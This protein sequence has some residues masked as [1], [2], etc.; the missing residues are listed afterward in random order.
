MQDN[1][2]A[3]STIYI[4]NISEDVWPFISAMSDNQAKAYEID[5]NALL[6]DRH[7]FSNLGEENILLILPTQIEPDFMDYFM[8]LFTGKNIR[9]IV[10]KIHTGEICNDILKDPN[11]MAEID[12]AANSS[13]RLEIVSYSASLQFLHLIRTLKQKHT[14]II[15]PESP[16]EEDAWTINFFGSKSGIRQLAQQSGTF[17]PDFK[18]PDGLICMGI[19]DA[20]KIAAN[21]YITEHGVVLKTNK[22]H[23]GAGVL[24]FRPGDLPLEYT[25][26]QVTINEL[27]QKDKY[28]KLFPIIIE[29]YI[30]P[31]PAI[32]GGFPNVEFKILKS[33][34]VDFLYYCGMRVTPQGVF[35]G[36]EVNDES[37][38]DRIAAQITDTGFFVGER[39][40]RE[41]YRGHFDVDFIAAKNSDLYV[42]ESN[43]RRTGGSHVYYTSLALFGKD[44]MHT[45]YSLSN[46]G[47][48]LPQSTQWNFKKLRS[49]LSPLLFNRTTKEGLIIVAANSVRR[50]NFYY[51]VFGNNKKRALDIEAQME[52]LLKQSTPAT[53]R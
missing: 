28:W 32:G 27:L 35:K 5:E 9:I 20:S 41:G 31:N 12:S 1:Q 10:P 33:G 46:D 8:E 4:S 45:T 15:T 50:G 3:T 6:A 24:I 37:L 44:F 21:K 2:P 47:H 29:S 19:E 40:A 53:L 23:S 52:T 39:L 7:L 42:T 17:E 18:M 30:P 14:N 22:G 43:V 36:V 11:I 16:E 26:C 48:Q 34:R 51:I 38:N 13:Q 25:A 49:L